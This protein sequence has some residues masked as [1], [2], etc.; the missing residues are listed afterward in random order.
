M[1]SYKDNIYT[2]VYVAANTGL[3][4]RTTH[5]TLTYCADTMSMLL[6]SNAALSMVIYKVV[7]NVEVEIDDDEVSA[8][9]DRLCDIL[10][11]ED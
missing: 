5:T 3:T 8:V 4:H 10:R 6:E 7:D 1:D 9:E 2:F 11:D